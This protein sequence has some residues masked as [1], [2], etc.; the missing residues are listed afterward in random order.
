MPNVLP[1]GKWVTG[2]IKR[3]PGGK[4]VMK[5]ANPGV[6]KNVEMGFYDGTGFH[7]IRA[8]SDYQESRAGE[9]R[10]ASSPTAD[11]DRRRREATNRDR[12][13]SRVGAKKKRKGVKAATK[14]TKKKTA[15]R[16]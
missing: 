16:R 7:P 5:T 4:L 10:R 6:R 15:R 1:I 3:L 8:S 11:L 12:Y 14:K 9:S 2:A 13:L